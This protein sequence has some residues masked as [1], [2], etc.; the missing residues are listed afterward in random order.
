ME[1]YHSA[2]MR[3]TSNWLIKNVIIAFVRA[4]IGNTDRTAHQTYL[5]IR[6]MEQFRVVRAVD[7]A[8][9]RLG[10][11]AIKQKQREAIEA[12]TKGEDVFVS[13]PTGY[14]KSLC[15]TLLPWVFDDLRGEKNTS[16]VVC[17]S[18][19]TSL[20]IDQRKKYTPSGLAAEFVGGVQEDSGV[21]DKIEKG[22][23]QL[24]YISPESLLRENRWREMLRSDV[25]Q[26]N[27]VAFCVDEAHCVKKW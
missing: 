20:M 3:R 24:V 11:Q 19:L 12:F 17:V 18:P 6:R 2:G 13:L 7:D 4:F 23:Y 26:K 25:Y 15:Y 8:V 21:L 9:A 27:M 14:G 22:C 5:P 1:V 10:Y 16:I